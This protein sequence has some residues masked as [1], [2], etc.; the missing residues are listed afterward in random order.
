MINAHFW[1]QF[2]FVFKTLVILPF[3]CL[4]R[5]RKIQL[6]FYGSKH[7]LF[8]PLCTLDLF[9]FFFSRFVFS[10]VA[11]RSIGY[12]NKPS[13]KYGRMEYRIMVF[14]RCYKCI[15]TTCWCMHACFNPVHVC[16]QDWPI[17]CKLRC[18][19][20]ITTILLPV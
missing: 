20:K 2:G 19:R 1:S 18:Q 6:F 7:C 13:S 12:H 16:L 5:V 8:S 9:V 17:V 11:G 10:K 4:S 14:G 15:R 3:E